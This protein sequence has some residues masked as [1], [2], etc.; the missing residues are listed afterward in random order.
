MTGGPALEPDEVDEDPD[1]WRSYQPEGD[2]W[3]DREYSLFLRDPAN[4]AWLYGFEKN[5]LAQA[6][7]SKLDTPIYSGDSNLERFAVACEA[8]R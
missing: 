2:C 5:E 7:R 6:A 3:F 4:M 8:A 1:R